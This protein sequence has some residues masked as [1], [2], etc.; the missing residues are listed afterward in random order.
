MLRHKED[1]DLEKKWAGTRW[2]E[3]GYVFTTRIGT[4]T[5]P[6]D[7]LQDYY[8]ITRLKAKEGEA[9]PVP[10]FPAIRLHDL[11]YSA[12]T[13][14][15]AQGVSAR[16]ITN[17]LGTPRC[18]LPSRP[19]HTF[20]PARSGRLLSKS[21]EILGPGPVATKRVAPLRNSS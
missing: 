5:D 9:A 17:L 11:C 6:R 12:A 10:K 8:A 15:L 13:L 18:P 14:L 7:L 4:P 19:M 1:Q 2:K 21:D 3:T 16:Y 20:C